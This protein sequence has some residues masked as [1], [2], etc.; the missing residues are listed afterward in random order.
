MPNYDDY[1]M[2]SYSAD[3]SD[4]LFTMVDGRILYRN[5]E[6]TAIDEERLR[7]EAQEVFAHYF[8]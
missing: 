2:L 7:Y 1:A 3:A 4:V 8:D 6:Y 5:G